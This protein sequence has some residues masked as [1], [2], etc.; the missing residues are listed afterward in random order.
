MQKLSLLT[1]WRFVTSDVRPERARSFDPCGD[2]R[3]DPLAHP[4]LAAMSQR[5][6]ADLPLSQLRMR[7]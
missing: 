1:F 4:D 2:F 5:E 7:W 3:R 6:L